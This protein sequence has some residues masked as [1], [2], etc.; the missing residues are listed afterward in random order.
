MKTLNFAQSTNF[1]A[2]CPQFGGMEFFIQ[3]AS[4]PGISFTLPTSSSQGMVHH[5]PT[6]S[7]SHGDLTITALLD[8]DFE[9]YNMFYNE[10]LKCKDSTNPSYAQRYF[11]LYIQVN[12]NKGNPLFTVTFHNCLIQTI[13]DVD[14]DT[15]DSSVS[16]TINIT[17]TY[18][19][20]DVKR[21]GLTEE[22][23]REFNVYPPKEPES[24]CG[25]GCECDCKCN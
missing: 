17:I 21:E 1:I 9:L 10:M 11:D 16:Q 5:H 20:H 6:D 23:R 24:K 13:G 14:L 12:N 25:C 22:Q 19:W 4:L 15:T 7:Y 2:G 18:D 3:K 8:E